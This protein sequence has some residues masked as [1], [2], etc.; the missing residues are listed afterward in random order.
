MKLQKQKNDEEETC[1]IPKESISLTAVL[2]F[3][4]FIFVLLAGMLFYLRY[5]SWS[6]FADIF[7]KKIP[8]SIG[9]SDLYNKNKN[10][11]GGETAE[12]K[13]TEDALAQ[14]VGVTNPDFPLKKPILSIKPEGIL[15]SGKTS[16]SFLGVPIDVL[17]EPKVENDK[18]VFSI[19]EIKAGGVIAPPKISNSLTPK[20]NGIFKNAF[21]GSENLTIVSVRTLV[22]Y[23]IIEVK[24]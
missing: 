16:T 9:F 5:S 2:V 3:L 21:T 15:I 14:S 4:G 6:P 13:I 20:M 24:K 22:R 7:Q 17:F 12:I 23:L 18:L 8:Q 11:S 1:E 10:Q 19:K